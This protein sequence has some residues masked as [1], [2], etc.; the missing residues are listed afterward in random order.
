MDALAA[1]KRYNNVQLDGKPMNIEIVGTN[2]ETPATVPQISN[3]AFG[4]INGAPKRLLLIAL[5]LR[6]AVFY[7]F[8]IQIV[9]SELYLFGELLSYSLKDFFYRIFLLRA[10]IHVYM[11]PFVMINC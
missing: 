11:P 9:T 1:V 3:G 10:C 8:Y 5:Q 7:I 4:S 6:C 2:I